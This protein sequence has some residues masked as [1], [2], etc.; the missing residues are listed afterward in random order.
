MEQLRQQLAG[1][2]KGLRELGGETS[3]LQVVMN[4]TTVLTNFFCRV[5][6]PADGSML[7]GM[8]N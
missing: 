3:V 6:R 1:R 2:T 7:Q 4:A 5:Q 8:I